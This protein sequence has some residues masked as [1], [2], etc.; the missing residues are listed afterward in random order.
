[1][2]DVNVSDEDGLLSRS[3][4]IGANDCFMWERMLINEF[5]ASEFVFQSLHPETGAPWHDATSLK[6]QRSPI[7]T[8]SLSVGL[9]IRLIQ[10]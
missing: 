10:L 9:H 1:M 6:V 7:G 8:L 2:N 4:T 3:T 5:V